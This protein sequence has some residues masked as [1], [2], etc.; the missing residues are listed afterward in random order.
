MLV[1]FDDF[2]RAVEI[3]AGHA[4]VF[5]DLW[6]LG[7]VEENDGTVG[8][9]GSAGRVIVPEGREV[10]L[11]GA[12][13]ALGGRGDGAADGEFGHPVAAGNFP[14]GVVE[15]FA[16]E[17]IG[18]GVGVDGG[19]G[20]VPR[21]AVDGGGFVV[22][23]AFQLRRGG[24]RR[25]EDV[26]AFPVADFRVE[27][28]HDRLHAR[29]RDLRQALR[30]R[31]DGA[32]FAA[33]EAVEDDLADGGLA[34]FPVNR[35][36]IAAVEVGDGEVAGVPVGIDEGVAEGGGV[37]A[38][39]GGGEGKLHELG[40]HGG[41]G[42][43]TDDGAVVAER[44][45][46]VGVGQERRDV[47]GDT[48]GIGGIDGGN[49]VRQEIA[50]GGGPGRLG[51][52]GI[53]RGV[54]GN[55]G[56]GKGVEEEVAPVVV[57]G[58]R[59]GKRQDRAGQAAGGGAEELGGNREE[60]SGLVVHV[61]RLAV[62]RAVEDELEVG[63]RKI[64][65]AGVN[66]GGVGGAQL[67]DMGQGAGRQGKR[68]ACRGSEEREDAFLD[69]FHGDGLSIYISVNIGLPTPQPFSCQA[70]RPLLCPSPFA[71]LHWPGGVTGGP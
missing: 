3:H 45:G 42:V 48:G 50:A 56:G 4:A 36:G 66:P 1:E 23:M 69:A 32:A 37:V 71:L 49:G 53:P 54:R 12:G 5:L 70:F 55:E 26:L 35:G 11:G 2:I 14:R 33:V 28:R 18:G 41:L 15:G 61:G 44:G 47:E 7:G 30:H 65:V 57:P 20:A 31:Q 6:K 59:G 10:E 40:V 19:V 64:G 63:G 60:E 27:L 67:E 25:K 58:E 43:E 38:G 13:G 21:G 8:E 68:Q 51:P 16:V 24:Q 29:G 52:A 17:D 22:G 62:R 34:L 46:G 39:G 9:E